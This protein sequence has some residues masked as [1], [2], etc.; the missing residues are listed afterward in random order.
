[1]ES[2]SEVTVQRPCRPCLPCCLISKD[3][4]RPQNPATLLSGPRH[5]P[6]FRSQPPT[7]VG[8]AGSLHPGPESNHEPR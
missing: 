8:T 1:M 3:G 6:H 7:K 5:M 2:R 4:G